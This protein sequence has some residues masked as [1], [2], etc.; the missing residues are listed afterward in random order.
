MS[1]KLTIE[2]IDGIIQHQEIQSK[3]I[4]LGKDNYDNEQDFKNAVQ[5][6]GWNLMALNELK[7]YRDAGITIDA[8][9]GGRVV[10][11]PVDFKERGLLLPMNLIMD[12]FERMWESEK[13]ALEEME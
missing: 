13:K 1:D 4:R 8:I 9:N 5:L 2:Q 3:L 12:A 10:V 7:S 11:L 6:E